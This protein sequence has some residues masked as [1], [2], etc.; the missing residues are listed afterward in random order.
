MS[1]SSSPDDALDSRGYFWPAG[2]E[3]L[4]GRIGPASS[5][6]GRLRVRADGVSELE[7]DG[8]VGTPD[9]TRRMLV[10]GTVSSSI[11]GILTD[12]GRNVLLS[13][14]SGNGA[15]SGGGPSRERLIARRC[16]VASVRNVNVAGEGFRSLELPLD[17]F[18]DWVGRGGISVDDRKRSVKAAY[19]KGRPA[20]W[21][22]RE[23]TMQLARDLRGNAGD[24]LSALTWREHAELRMEFAEE[25]LTLDRAV[26]LTDRVEDLLVLL[27]DCDRALDFPWLR[28]EGDGPR[29]RLYFA[30]SSRSTQEKVEWSRA[31]LPFGAC[32]AEF[33]GIL[34]K[35]LVDHEVYGPGFHLYLGNRRGQSMYL[36]HRFVSLMWGLESLHRSH[37]P[38]KAN[39]ALKKKVTRILDQITAKKDKEW[40]ARFLP[41]GVEPTLAAR[42]FELVSLLPL[43]FDKT[44]LT[45]FA[46]WCAARRND[47]SHFGGVRQHGDYDAFLSDI[48]RLVPAI[49]VLYHAILLK[50]IGVPDDR[51][52]WNFLDGF[53][54]K[55]NEL[56]LSACNLRY[57][58]KT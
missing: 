49:E 11:A 18:E 34:E 1:Y 44:E 14:V 43:S 27:T 50:I 33:G 25:D 19:S 36:E 47:I 26:Q 9:F 48:V 29:I 40:A 52:A 10:P 42:I 4:A 57:E 46:T 54:S 16:L 41:T 31:W 32:T 28:R 15:Q 35:W 53:I 56:K 51:L 13:E 23:M 55:P 17:G 6:S 7:T 37:V 12:G 24:Q 38:T 58:R 8:I 45:A 39:P 30:R 2:D 5:L 21:K 22:L 20:K 3:V